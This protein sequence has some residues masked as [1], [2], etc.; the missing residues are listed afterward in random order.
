MVRAM[1][2]AG[3][4][5]AVT[6]ATL[7]LGPLHARADTAKAWSAAKAGLPGDA[8]VVFAIDFAALQKTQVFAALWPK[9]LEKFDAT[10][11]MDAM[12][13]DCK[14]DPLTSVQGAVIA[15]SDGQREGA[16][17]VA[18]AGLD[19]AKLSSC[20]QREMEKN[21]DKDAKVVIKQDGNIT[22]V[23][24]GKDSMFL[25]WV[26]KDVVV[27]PLTTRDRA[28]VVKWMTGK[29][30]FGKTG[31]GKTLA[32]VNTSAALWGA[33][34]GND[35]FQP[36]VTV[37]GGYGSVLFAKGNVDAN[38]HAQAENAAQAKTMADS[39]QKQLDGARSNPLLP[40]SI[41][42]MLNAVS[43]AT[44]NDEVVIKAIVVEKDLLG[45]LTLA[46]GTL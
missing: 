21:G 37:K 45:A 14:I 32:R 20:L 11:V 1:G 8:K 31:V 5:V 33:G 17:Y 24:D 42:G 46:L 4:L 39:T 26:S 44:V 40:A 22:Q 3:C 18:L 7:A 35:E 9:L 2:I 10:K 43:I 25:G 13:A 12:K 16:A 36:G 38:L 23:T 27:V 6:T 41:A 15:M 30:A 28:T 19:K 29:G 34:E